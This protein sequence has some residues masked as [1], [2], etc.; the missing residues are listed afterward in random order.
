MYLE[1]DVWTLKR[2]EY[3][4]TH[5]RYS[6]S[7]SID[8]S[9]M[10]QLVFNLLD[11]DM[12]SFQNSMR[13]FDCWGLNFDKLY[14]HII[15]QFIHSNTIQKVMIFFNPREGDG[16]V[17][18]GFHN[19]VMHALFFRLSFWGPRLVHSCR[20]LPLSKLAAS[21]SSLLYQISQN[22]TKTY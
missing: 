9:W 14:R 6:P 8:S 15:S 20:P 3:V 18:L 11:N 2:Q 1:I 16:V 12:S 5:L 19:I 22:S 10:I 21:T 13:Q 17:S 4:N 7:A